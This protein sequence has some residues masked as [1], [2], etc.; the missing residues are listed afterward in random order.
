[1]LLYAE[2]LPLM[3]GG[4]TF[5]INDRSLRTLVCEAIAWIPVVR[6]PMLSSY[7]GLETKSRAKTLLLASAIPTCSKS[8]LEIS[9]SVDGGW[10]FVRK[11]VGRISKDSAVSARVVVWEL[12]SG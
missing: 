7:G 1:M 6:P 8:R 12:R 2:G 3:A 10:M 5:R 9:L 4:S 11:S